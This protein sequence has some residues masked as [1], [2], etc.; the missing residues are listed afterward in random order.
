MMDD[1]NQLKHEYLAKGG[2]DPAFIKK[3]SNLEGFLEHGR[4]IEPVQREPAF[5]VNPATNEI[6]ISQAPPM[7]GPS[8]FGGPISGMPPMPMPGTM[9]PM[10]GGAMP[11]MPPPFPG[12]PQDPVFQTMNNILEQQA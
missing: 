2:E 10:M 6:R 3:L 5:P 12:G 11:G 8:P 4:K 9:P 1:L 7:A